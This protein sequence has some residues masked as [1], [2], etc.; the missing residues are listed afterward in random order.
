MNFEDVLV[1]TDSLLAAV[2]LDPREWESSQDAAIQKELRQRFDESS[3]RMSC[4]WRG[5]F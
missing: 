4:D 1:G 2:V 5:S 3:A